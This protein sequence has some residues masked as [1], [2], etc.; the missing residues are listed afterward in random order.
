MTRKATAFCAVLAAG[1]LL[2]QLAAADTDAERMKDLEQR[3]M[4]LEDKLEAS[5]ATIEAQRELLRDHGAPAVSQGSALD[6]FFSG[7]EVGGHVTAS[8]I[9]NFGRPDR[10]GQLGD[11]N[12]Q[13]LNQF[14]NDHESFKLDAVKLEIGKPAAEPGTA[15]FQIDI[16]WG[17]N[18]DI[19][20]GVNTAD[21]RISYIQEAY[22]AYNYEGINLALG[23]WETLLGYE[24]LDSPLNPNITHGVLFTWAIPLV[25]TGLLAS[26]SVNENVGWA[27]GVA[28]GFN[29][30]TDTNDNKA[31]LGQVNFTQGPMFG[32]A[33]IYYGADGSFSGGNGVRSGNQSDQIIVDVVGTYDIGDTTH[34]WL[35]ADY[36]RQQDVVFGAGSPFF[37]RGA[38]DSAWWGVAAG[39][40]QQLTDKIYAALR[41][42]HFKD[43]EGYRFFGTRGL[44]S[45]DISVQTLT[46]TL[47]VNLTQQLLARAELRYDQIKAD[48]DQDELVFLRKNGRTDDN[49]WLGIVEV[50]YN[51]D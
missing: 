7:L 42:E 31:V 12:N 19:L 46:G 15:G 28:N 29:N 25:H 13:P 10:A 8:Y 9:H 23:K 37:G 40:K 17:D 44:S 24:L 39:V 21:D 4:A 16:L 48:R 33:S 49:Q 20:G 45:S 43:E 50:S 32:S 22:A 2:P 30:I 35:N 3:L 14:N 41:A 51:F 11:V 18:A 6:A 47:G 27:L 26:G 36:G 38:K 5:S 34:I 1:L